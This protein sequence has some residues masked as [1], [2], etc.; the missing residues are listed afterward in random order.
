MFATM[1][2]QNMFCRFEIASHKAIQEN[3]SA[4]FEELSEIYYKELQQVFGSTVE[5]P[6]E[7]KSE[8][9]SIPH[10]FSVPFYVYAYNFANLLVIA[11]YQ[12]F[13]EEGSSFVPM[14]KSLLKSGGKQSPKELLSPLGI[15]LD[16][17]DF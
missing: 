14:Y 3:G 13:K 8:W 1:F 15:Q 5:I 2:R 17:A 6:N 11:L 4:A 10:I 9:A 7:Y 12:K 16:S